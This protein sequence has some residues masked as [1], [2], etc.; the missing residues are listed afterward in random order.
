KDV[1]VAIYQS[2]VT[3]DTIAAIELAKENQSLVYGICN[4][5]GSTIS[6]MSHAGSYTHAGQEIGIA[7]T[8]AFTTQVVILTLMA[9]QLADY[10]GNLSKSQLTTVLV[11]LENVPSKVREIIKLDEKIKEIA[12]EYYEANNFLFL[13]RG[14]NY[15]IALEALKL[16]EIS[17]IHAEGY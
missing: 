17:Y 6:R 8:K 7:S 11:E 4:S 16:K 10:K 13:G 5:V 14:A 2:A 12:K 9:L 15:P 1:F 3:A